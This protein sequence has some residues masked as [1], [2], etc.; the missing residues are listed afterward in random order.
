[1]NCPKCGHPIDEKTKICPN[2]KK[3]LQLEC[4]VCK[5]LNKTNTCYNCGFVIVNK[6][7][8]CG[9]INQ[10]ILGKCSKCGFNTYVSAILNDSNIE[11]FACL[12][13][14][15]P[16]LD[17]MTKFLGSKALLKK[18]KEK[19]N[20]KIYEYAKSKKLKRHVIDNTY[21]IR[22]NKDYTYTAS[23]KNAMLSA[24]E[25]LNMITELNVKL[26]KKRKTLLKCNMAI[27]KRDA[28]SPGEDYKSGINIQILYKDVLEQKY[29]NSLQLV[30]DNSINQALSNDY[31]MNSI[32]L[33][34]AKNRTTMMYE[35]NLNKLIKVVEKNEN[36][37]E[38][39][40]IQTINKPLISQLIANEEELE[41]DNDSIYDVD[42]ISFDE[43]DC[44]F[45][46]VYSKE[47]TSEIAN[48]FCNEKKQIISVKTSSSNQPRTEEL[49]AKI[50]QNGIFNKIFK[51]TC[52][53]NMKYKP[54]GFFY[55]LISSVYNFSTTNK[56]FSTNDF[57]RFSN[58]NNSS[59][60]TDM[61]N[62]NIRELLSPEDVRFALLSNFESLFGL[63]KNTLIFIENVELIDET[64]YEIL[65]L[66]L[67]KF[68]EF[69]ISYIF[70]GDKD[71]S[72]HKASHF[73]LSKKA[74]TEITVKLTPAKILIES[75]LKLYENI[76]E[77]FYMNKLVQNTHGSPMYFMQ[78]TIYL[79][80]MG[81]L[82]VND[83]SLEIMN[84]KTVILPTNLD[85][86]IKKMM[87]NICEKLN[88]EFRLL[89]CLL[90]LGTRIDSATL[91]SLEFEDLDK[92]LQYL[93][94]KGYIYIF[95]NAVYFQNYNLYYKNLMEILERKEKQAICAFLSDKCFSKETIHPTKIFLYN[96]LEDSKNELSEYKNLSDINKS[97]GDF[98]AYLNCS[99]K[100][101]K[102]L[103]S[104]FVE[105]SEKSIDDYKM[106]IYENISN[107]LY[108]YSPEK[109]YNITQIIL[110]NLE[111]NVENNKVITLCNKMMQ[112]CLNTGNYTY[113]L[114][115]CHKILSKLE[116]SDI[117]PQNEN[118]N[119]TAFMISLIK[120]EI[121]FNVGN[122]EECIA[123][124]EE[125]FIILLKNPRE[126]I[127]SHTISDALFE[128]LLTDSAGYITLSKIAQLKTN[129]KDFLK[130]AKNVIGYLP[131]S[132]RLFD[133]LYN[134]IRNKKFEYDFY[135]EDNNDRFEKFNI[136]LLIAFS[137]IISDYQDFATKI[138]H[139]KLGAKA[140]NLHQL[141]LLSDLMIGYAYFKLQNVRKASKIYTSVLETA[142][143]KGLNNIKLIAWYLIAK[144]HISKNEVDIASG[145]ANNALV[146]LEKDLYSNPYILMLYKFLMS[147]CLKLKN[148]DTQANFCY[149]Q[150]VEIAEKNN[151]NF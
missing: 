32:G 24:I 1:M 2:C 12:T 94:A 128:T 47:L 109:I 118:F 95:E 5:E 101:L 9:K 76:L 127:K 108:K 138:Y 27:L 8:N 132:Y 121:L 45:I 140:N 122:L 116:K 77:S 79:M 81:V 150:A 14:E 20:S 46:K 70:L 80:D 110:D 26:L 7:N 28:Y 85:D 139:A 73:L 66:L 60:L 16:N 102:L 135:E 59:Y 50:A 119:P 104:T 13:L 98:S 53:E 38:S 39:E 35:V 58:I 117:H 149:N 42:G 22:F 30:V 120:L 89:A 100:L 21:I 41:E 96:I 15:F 114:E 107:L 11:E 6:C 55:D 71:F 56:F 44:K 23:A 145:L 61:I 62:L 48:L 43:I 69:D 113:A 134:L 25:I 125:L 137:K 143:N 105:N 54:Y 90:F 10:T 99:I 52:Y 103:D 86:L 136:N 65:Q 67:E 74:Y 31:E 57:S 106:E 51:V 131:Q 33:T 29:L 83:G 124:G 147:E 129:H 82:K 36:E 123:L 34:Q 72:L 92:K 63:M 151:I 84:E 144:I 49:L 111:N 64:S 4:P 87:Q 91:Q 78:A 19:L 17:G 18:F 97:L 133:E 37:I 115:L 88:D 142:T 148:E 68:D 126:K 112:G 93:E 40:K 3:V 130:T 75:N 146:E 141:E